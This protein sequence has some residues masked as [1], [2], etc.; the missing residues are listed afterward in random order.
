MGGA[1]DDTFAGFRL[2][3]APQ[4]PPAR[5]NQ[6]VRTVAVDH[7]E[8]DFGVKRRGVNGQPHA[9]FCKPASAVRLDLAQVPVV[10]TSR[11]RIIAISERVPKV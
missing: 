5:E 6:R 11:R 2:D 10:E 8:F 7:G 1:D 3:P 4:R 9:G